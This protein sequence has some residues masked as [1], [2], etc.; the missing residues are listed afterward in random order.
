MRTVRTNQGT[1]EIVQILVKGSQKV[2]LRTGVQ[3]SN[4]VVDKICVK[5]AELCEICGIRVGCVAIDRAIVG[6]WRQRVL[7]EDKVDTASDDIKGNGCV[8]PKEPIWET[9]VLEE[10]SC[11]VH[12]E[13]Q[14]LIAT[15]DK[16]CDGEYGLGICGEVS[17]RDEAELGIGGDRVLDSLEPEFCGNGEVVETGTKF[18]TEGG[19]LEGKIMSNLYVG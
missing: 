10:S 8:G 1:I 17:G 7:G 4:C 12:V 14:A 9:A 13:L 6:T 19:Q 3:P 11:N 16:E 5:L 18:V 15:V 2:T